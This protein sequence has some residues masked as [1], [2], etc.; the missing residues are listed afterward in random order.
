MVLPVLVVFLKPA[1]PANALHSAALPLLL[2]LA[3][4]NPIAFREATQTLEG[5]QR[6]KLESS[7]R[8]SAGSDGAASSAPA[9]AATIDL[10]V[11]F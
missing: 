3:G 4:Q 2:N 8:Q 10:K 11:D 7:V 1:E 6:V 9:R 5:S